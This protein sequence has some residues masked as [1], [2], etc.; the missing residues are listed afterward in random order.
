VVAVI[1]SGI[2]FTHPDL[3]N[4][5]WTN[6]NESANGVDDDHDGFVDDH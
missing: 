4:E 6:A 3:Q 2:N 1:D 5:Q